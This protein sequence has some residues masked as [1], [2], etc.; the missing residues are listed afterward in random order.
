MIV[1][2]DNKRLPI[3]FNVMRFS[4]K[5]EDLH[6]SE[7]L[8]TN[9]MTIKEYYTPFERA[10]GRLNLATTVN[11]AIKAPT[12]SV[13]EWPLRSIPT[14]LTGFSA[15]LRPSEN[16]SLGRC[17]FRSPSRIFRRPHHQISG[18]RRHM[19]SRRNGEAP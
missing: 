15:A 19:G 8:S 13:K 7:E 16:S 12:P 5:A 14:E 10:P 17:R 4:G 11:D 2:G 9:S 18:R 3:T 1:F 6:D